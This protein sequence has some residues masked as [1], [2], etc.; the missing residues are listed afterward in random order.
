[1]MG[2]LLSNCKHCVVKGLN[3]VGNHLKHDFPRFIDNSST[4]LT[5][6]LDLDYDTDFVYQG[7]NSK[8][9]L[10]HVFNLNSS[11]FASNSNGWKNYMLSDIG[12]AGASLSIMSNGICERCYSDDIRVEQCNIE[13][14]QNGIGAGRHTGNRAVRN[15]RIKNCKA[16]NIIY[17]PLGFHASHCTVENFYADCC[18]QS[19]DFSARCDNV[20]V[21]NSVFTNCACGPKQESAPHL[22]SMTFGNKIN[23]CIFEIND[24]KYGLV[25]TGTATNFILKSAESINETYGI[26]EI[27]NTV[28]IMN[29]QRNFSNV[30]NRAYM[31]SLDT[32]N[33]YI[34]KDYYVKVAGNIYEQSIGNKTI[35]LDGKRYII[36]HDNSNTYS[37]TQLPTFITFEG[38]WGWT[39]ANNH[40][41]MTSFTNTKI[42]F[43]KNIKVT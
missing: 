32:V 42:Y 16:Y 26:F 24:T 2:L 22:A 41:P 43:G 31:L 35:A 4:D 33:F 10:N 14:R 6:D 12:V 13:M 18:L 1:M 38:I 11:I 8:F 21:K 23:N 29:K 9:K 19:I 36:A 3:W 39:D 30:I 25:D 34:N 37:N 7:S 28:F 17:Q 5:T 40:C 15:V 27:Y 20:T